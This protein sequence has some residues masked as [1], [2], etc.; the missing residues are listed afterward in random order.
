MVDHLFL[1]LDP[2][3]DGEHER[4]GDGD[5]AGNGCDCQ[6]LDPLDRPP[7]EVAGVIASGIVTVLALWRADPPDDLRRALRAAAPYLLL[8]AALLAARL[9]PQPPGWKP[10][11]AFP[12]FPITHVAV[13]LLLVALGVML[14]RG[15]LGEAPAALRRA[16]RPALAMLLYVLLGRWL[17][18]SGIAAGLAEDLHQL[19]HAAFLIGSA[20]PPRGFAAGNE[21]EIGSSISSN[22]SRDRR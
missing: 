21:R 20:C 19:V 11:A 5:G 18:G 12:A 10:F 7:A 1:V 22:G 16:A 6:T 13:V 17:A 9:W 2:D 4:D 15:R 8:V 3:A 14:A